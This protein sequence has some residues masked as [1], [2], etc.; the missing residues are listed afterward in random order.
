MMM[1]GQ[2]R[3][4]GEAAGGAPEANHHPVSGFRLVTA[5]AFRCLPWSGLGAAFKGC[6]LSFPLSWLKLASSLVNQTQ[7]VIFHASSPRSH[8][9][10]LLAW[11]QR[12]L[13]GWSLGL[14]LY[15]LSRRAGATQLYHL[16]DCHKREGRSDWCLSDKCSSALT[17]LLRSASGSCLLG[18]FLPLFWMSV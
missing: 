7:S 16:C 4:P 6:L 14:H 10:L 3:E 1:T 18:W 15:C 11:N 8:F 2:E 17:C 12:W 9:I 5:L 13:P